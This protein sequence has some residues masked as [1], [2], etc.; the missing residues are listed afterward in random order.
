MFTKEDLQMYAEELG[1]RVTTADDLLSE[2][3]AL[4]FFVARELLKDDLTEVDSL[5]VWVH[6]LEF[7]EG[8][9][10]CYLQAYQRLQERRKN[11]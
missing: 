5:F 3:T 1:Y 11:G 10:N 7:F 6:D 2:A 4:G 8:A 9:Y